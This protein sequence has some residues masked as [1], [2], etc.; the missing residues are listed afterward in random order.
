MPDSDDKIY[1]L[2]APTCGYGFRVNHTKEVYNNCEQWST[3]NDTKCSEDVLWHYQA[4]VDDDLDP[5]HKPTN[6]DTEKND[7]GTGTISIPGT[8]H[9][10][11][12]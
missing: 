10:T 1:D 5:E 4:W 7:V 11:P 3:W 2:D 12:R 9:Y 6:D 8:A